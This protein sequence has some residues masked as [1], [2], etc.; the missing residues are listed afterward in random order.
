[1]FKGTGAAASVAGGR[2]ERREERRWA[3][4]RGAGRPGRVRQAVRRGSY[5]EQHG[6]LN[7][8]GLS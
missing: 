8:Q 2:S 6:S 5:S 1:M 7:E 3:G 4:E